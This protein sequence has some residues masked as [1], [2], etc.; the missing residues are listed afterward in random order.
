M[1]LSMRIILAVAVL[2]GALRAGAQA[3]V[4]FNRDILPILES[5]CF[6]CHDAKVHSSVTA[7]TRLQAIAAST[8]LPP[9]CSMLIPASVASG[10]L[11]ATMPDRPTAG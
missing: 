9:D 1:S 6:E 5:R 4:D 2:A 11:V 3:P 10:W 8:A 7:S